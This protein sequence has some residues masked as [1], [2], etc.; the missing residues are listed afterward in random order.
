MKEEMKSHYYHAYNEYRGADIDVL[1]VH[2]DLEKAGYIAEF[3]GRINCNYIHTNAPDEIV[4]EL[5]IKHNRK[6]SK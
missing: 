4:K 5:E 6:E 1:G 3:D 2:G